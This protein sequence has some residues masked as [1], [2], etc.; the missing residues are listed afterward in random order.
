MQEMKQHFC[1]INVR[2]LSKTLRKA[3]NILSYATFL[4][5]FSQSLPSFIGV[6]GWLEVTQ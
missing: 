4:G 5:P 1:A 3:N 2:T 6:V